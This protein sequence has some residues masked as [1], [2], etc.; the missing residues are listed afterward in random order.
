M[1]TSKNKLMSL[2]SVLTTQF[3][4]FTQKN[5]TEATFNFKV[6]TLIHEIDM[7]PYKDELLDLMYDQLMDDMTTQYEG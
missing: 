1:I 4:T 3:T 6:D 5:M 2:L 7:H